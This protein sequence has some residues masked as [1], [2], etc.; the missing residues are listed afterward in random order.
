MKSIHPCGAPGRTVAGALALGALLAGCAS[1][2]DSNAGE[3]AILAEASPAADLVPFRV[4]EPVGP[5]TDLPPNELGEIMV[6]EYHRL[7]TP[8]GEWR[9]S[10]DNFRAD[11]RRLYE[12]GYRPITVRQMVDGD[13]D[14][15]RGTTPVVFTFDDS[16]QGQYYLLPDGSV[17]PSTMV[18][19]WEAF[20]E[21][22]PGWEGGATWCVLPGAD[23]PSNFF[24][25]RPRSEVPRE[26]RER[27]I[28]TK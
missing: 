27:T 13:L 10:L 21:A 1:E 18:G 15:P 8:E 23:H 26:E 25:E 5:A 14:V 16:S 24:G 7:G 9:R 3:A 11:L 20:R 12:A 19:V 17:D 22:N 6:L 4:R 2:V 28:Q